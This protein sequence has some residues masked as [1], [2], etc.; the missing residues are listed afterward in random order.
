M[1]LVYPLYEDL[2]LKL[3]DTVITYF[4]FFEAL[5]NSQK[6]SVIP[7]CDSAEIVPLCAKP[8]MRYE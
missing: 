6:L 1:L 3:F 2:R 7:S 5:S 4:P 8:W